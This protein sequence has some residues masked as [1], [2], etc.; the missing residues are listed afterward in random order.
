[1]D[2][3][4]GPHVSTARLHAGAA[5]STCSSR[6]TRPTRT[7]RTLDAVRQRLH[8]RWLGRCVELQLRRSI[9]GAGSTSIR[10]AKPRRW[11]KHLVVPRVSD[12]DRRVARPGWRRQ[13]RA[14]VRR[15][16]ADA[17]R[18][19]RSGQSDRHVDRPATCPNAGSSPRTASAPATSTATAAP[20][21]SIRYGWWEQ[22]PS[23]HERSRG[24]TIRRRSAGTAARVGGSVMAVY[25]VNGDKLN[26][27]VTVLAAHGWG[28]AWFEQKR[29][30]RGSD[31]VRAV[32]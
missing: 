26:D 29:D 21:S 15:R 22:P 19:T 28:L 13:A 3:V 12:R 7:R 9:P 8:R 11:D 2:V 27:V 30:A 10:K 6:P 25:D 16:G 5:R 1:M 14:G 23:E 17:V 20:T 4:S 32:T 31:F 18:Q 24:L